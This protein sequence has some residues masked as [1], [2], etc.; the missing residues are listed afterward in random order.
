MKLPIYMEK[1]SLLY[2]ISVL[3]DSSTTLNFVSQDFLIRNN[4]LEKCNRGPKIIVQIANE[5]RMFTRKTFSPT[6]VSLGQKMFPSIIFTCL[7]HLKCVDFI[8]GLVAMK[9]LN[10]SV[11]PS[12]DLVLI[13]DIPF[14]C[15]SQPRSV[16][17]LL[18]DSFKMQKI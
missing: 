12:N 16:L 8:F 5:H 7:P 15:E 18:V 11:Q 13:G 6:N 2:N 10:M 4:L 9:E 1:D 17:C 3:I 14:P